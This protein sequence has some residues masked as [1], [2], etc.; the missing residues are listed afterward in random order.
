MYLGL[1]I[2]YGSVVF[3]DVHPTQV[4]SEA[5]TVK[6]IPRSNFT[7]V[8]GFTGLDFVFTLL[9]DIST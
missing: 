9:V 8:L 1:E 3:V 2:C 5:V 4:N 6:E 7:I